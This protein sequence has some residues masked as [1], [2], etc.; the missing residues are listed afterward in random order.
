VEQLVQ[1]R[2]GER[3]GKA[4]LLRVEAAA[5]LLFG[6]SH[7][8]THLRDILFQATHPGGTEDTYALHLAD[9]TTRRLIKGDSVSSR[10][11][12][13]W[14]PDGRSIAYV[15]EFDDHD[16]LYVLDT[17]GGTP[18][19]LAAQLG[20]SAHFP[21]WSP[22]G[23]SIL[24]T[25]GRT[26]EHE[27][28]YLIRG[29]GSGLRAVLSD[30]VNEYRYPSWAPDGRQFAVATWSRSGSAILVVD[31]ASGSRRQ[32]LAADTIYLDCP[33][34]SPKGDVLLLTVYPSSVYP[35]ENPSVND[36]RADLATLDFHSGR[37]RFVTTDRDK[38][39]NYGRWSRDAH[40]IV[41]QSDRH[42]PPFRDSTATHF[43]FDSLEI[44]IVRADG[45]GL[46]RL[47]T[48]TYFDGH[49]SW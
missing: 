47:T 27:G 3:V 9:L 32:V 18:R 33:Q 12:P 7:D 1:I 24:F 30:S 46:R 20:G 4:I 22:D 5:L 43:R 11:F 42:A 8:I 28:V 48:N 49:P 26:V 10:G 21:D 39:N 17:I 35:W 14:S 2:R 44:Y 6:C 19:Q 38:L 37:L 23:K 36:A 45:S 41:F 16:Q 40:W 25:A 13:E 34:W 15:R 29:D 31:V